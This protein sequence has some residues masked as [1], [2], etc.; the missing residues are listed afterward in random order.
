MM[1]INYPHF[2]NIIP[3]RAIIQASKLRIFEKVA[4]YISKN[5]V[6]GNHNDD[7]RAGVNIYPPIT[8]LTKSR[9]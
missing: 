6:N 5:L 8:E 1:K 9:S 7:T 4:V 3:M 2:L